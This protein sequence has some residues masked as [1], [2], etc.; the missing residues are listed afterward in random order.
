MDS[1]IPS[2]SRTKTSG[3][4]AAVRSHIILSGYPDQL[5]DLRADF[6]LIGE[7]AAEDDFQLADIADAVQRVSCESADGFGDD[8][9]DFALFAV[10]DHPH[11]IGALFCRG[12]G[13]TLVR[14]GA[15]QCPL[16]CAHNE[17]GVV[18]FL[19]VKAGQLFLKIGG[20][21]AVGGDPHL[22]VSSPAEGQGLG[23][24]YDDDF[25]LGVTHGFALLSQPSGAV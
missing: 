25:S 9:V 16:R 7:S 6:L 18:A 8:E 19:C 1:Y 2:Y 13:N 15:R 11:E 14:V 17:V 5:S 10:A 23:G 21:P 22:A 20:N 3:I 24:R 12:A 4:S